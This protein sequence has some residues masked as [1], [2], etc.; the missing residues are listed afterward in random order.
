M[1]LNWKSTTMEKVMGILYETSRALD[2]GLDYSEHCYQTFIMT[3]L[4][5]ENL[6]VNKEVTCNFRFKKIRF[7]YGRIDLLVTTQDEVI[8]IELK[9]N[10]QNKPK[11]LNQLKK[12]LTHY[13]SR[14]KVRGILAMYN[15]GVP[16][17][18]T[19]LSPV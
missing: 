7:G 15:C 5:Q 16:I 10:N 17:E 3:R 4:Q 9:A 1:K 18:I 8:I 12:Y 6:T 13:K 14:K 2:T 11:A 19:K